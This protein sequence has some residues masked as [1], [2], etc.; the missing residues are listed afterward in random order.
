MTL[1]PATRPSRLAA[2]LLAAGAVAQGSA[3]EPT[4]GIVELQAGRTSA[5]VELRGD[6][7]A[8]GEAELTQ[9]SPASNAWL[10]LRLR[11][12]GT[13]SATSYHLENTDPRVQHI[14]L[15]PVVPGRLLF[16][17]GDRNTA[18]TFWPGTALQQAAGA[19]GAYVQ[20]CEGRLLLRNP[21]RGHRSTL[22]AAT[23]F[24]RDHV[25]R[26]EQIVGFVKREFYRDAFV[27]RAG[28][29]AADPAAAGY[30]S[31]PGSPPD[32]RVPGAIARRAV[33]A[34]GL[35]IDLGAVG[36]T[37]LPGRWYVAADLDHV[38]VSI[39]MP[40]ILEAGD[41]VTT[42]P[43]PALD[44]VEADA[45]SF[46]VAFDLAAFD[47]G[48]ALGTEHP[49]L[50]WADRV[51]A[52]QRD[53]RLRGPDGIDS[54]APLV[55]TGTLAP[56]LLPRAVATFTGGFK[57]EHGAF[58]AG[59]LAA[60]NHGSHYGFVEQGVVFS[61]LQP[62]LATLLVRNDGA[63]EMKTW[64]RGD[65]RLLNT[66]RHARQNGVPL[67]DTGPDG[68]PT[69][70]RLVDRWVEGN[71]AASPEERERTLRAGACLVELP[72]HRFLVYGYFSAATPR[73]M[74]R[75]F[76]AYGCRYAMHL[77][78]NAL[79]HTYLALYPPAGRQRGVEHL[80][81]GMAVLDKSRGATLLPRF[82]AFADDR[83]FFYL[84]ARSVPP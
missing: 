51:R 35:G 17:A 62:G 19:R 58:H 50:G 23:E 60:V 55:R 77:D 8:S 26:G 20:L 30:A 45:L 48:Y 83:D 46:L 38:Y 64:Q 72:R 27:E 80:V 24:L 31:P 36:R 81:P 9:L 47:V 12:P 69:V 65:E 84:T 10:L 52:D 4:R 15:D 39:A 42:A 16:S 2:A 29:A 11:A 76:Q 25:W 57:R 63:V 6:S 82:L 13:A 7:G 43:R 41:S 78:M 74:A 34:E 28:S 71:W 66:V 79:E 56:T 53:D 75:V 61:T 21:V 3:A 49:R 33:V 44:P 40:R 22:E 70:G 68:A 37:L 54:A 18:C 67:I 5:R 73:A 32:A 14:A 1:R 59:A